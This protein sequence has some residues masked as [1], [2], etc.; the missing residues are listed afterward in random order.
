MIAACEMFVSFFAAVA[1]VLAA[2]GLYALFLRKRLYR[3]KENEGLFGEH[4]EKA[5]HEVV[6]D[7]VSIS[8]EAKRHRYMPVVQRTSALRDGAGGGATPC[9]AKA[10][11]VCRGKYR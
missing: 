6:F 2:H 1:V 7:D 11:P 4:Y 3:R 10:L 5:L 8:A 9:A